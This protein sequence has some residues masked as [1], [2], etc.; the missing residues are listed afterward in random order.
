MIIKRRYEWFGHLY[1][2]DAAAKAI[3]DA[4]YAK[5]GAAE[6][7]SKESVLKHLHFSIPD[8][9]NIGCGISGRT[10]AEIMNAFDAA[11]L[12]QPYDNGLTFRAVNHIEYEVSRSGSHIQ[13]RLVN[14]GP[15]GLYRIVG[16]VTVEDCGGFRISDNWHMTQPFEIG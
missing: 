11:D 16:F 10:Y 14:R 5:N 7:F 8:F 2:H 9:F 4:V 3:V 1:E 15:D 12:E 13:L 6:T